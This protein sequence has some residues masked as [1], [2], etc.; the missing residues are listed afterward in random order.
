MINQVLAEGDD[1]IE[2]EEGKSGQKTNGL[3]PGPDEEGFIDGL[4][5][6]PDEKGFIEGLSPTEIHSPESAPSS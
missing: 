1:E 5:P 6:G 4:S 2:E 3:S